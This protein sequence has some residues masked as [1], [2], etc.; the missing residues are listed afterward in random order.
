MHLRAIPLALLLLI[1]LVASAPAQTEAPG[2]DPATK[3]YDLESAVQRALDANPTMVG[4]R[5][6]LSGAGYDVWSA[7]SAMLPTASLT[8]GYNHKDRKPSTTTQGRQDYFSEHI[9]LSQPLFKGFALLSN[10]QKK[11]LT[12]DKAEASLNNVELQL[13]QTV[14]TQFFSL[15]KARM[16]VKSAEDSVARLESQLKVT[17]AF[18]EVGL[19]PKLDVLQAEVDLATAQQSLLTARNNVA[20][21]HARLN[22]LL[23]LPLEN[24]TQ[25]VGGLEDIS[26]FTQEFKQCLQTAFDTRPDII[27]AEKSVRIAAKDSNIAMADLL[28]AVSADMDYYKYGDDADLD[29]KNS[30]WNRSYQEYWT[31]SVNLTYSLKVAGGDVADYMSAEQNLRKMVASLEETKLDAGYEVKSKFLN[32]FEARDRIAVARKSVDA[33]KESYRMALARYQAQVGTNTDVLDAQA[34]VSSSEAELS[35]ALADYHTSLADLFVAMGIKN[36]SLK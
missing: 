20:T 35:L 9:N 14:Q 26:P 3:V 23:D 2:P 4:A 24:E 19:K 10:L 11:M 12:K 8:Y 25:Y 33:A 13:I 30:R 27:M 5:A 6:S 16:D 7:T 21:V 34:K 29:A 1:V 15:L 31:S 17:S 28:P 32:L 36:P 22:S 18:Y